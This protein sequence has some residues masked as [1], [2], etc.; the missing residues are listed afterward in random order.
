MYI[1]TTNRSGDSEVVDWA[2][3]KQNYLS[4]RT[5]LGVALPG[6]PR[7]FV[8]NTSEPENAKK[9]GALEELFGNSFEL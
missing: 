5:A 1:C 4:H 9:N 2:P 3:Q 7:T 6:G 8:G